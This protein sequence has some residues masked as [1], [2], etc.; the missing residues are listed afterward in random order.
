MYNKM[1]KISLSRNFQY[2]LVKSIL[3]SIL[4]PAAIILFSAW[5]FFGGTSAK[6]DTT[7]TTSNNSDSCKGMTKDTC[8]QDTCV[9][10][11]S[12]KMCLGAK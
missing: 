3:L 9:W 12:Q 8:K 5:F 1:V 7:A 2:K 6:P 4:I 10:D 11:P